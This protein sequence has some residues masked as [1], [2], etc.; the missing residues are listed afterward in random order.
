[1]FFVLPLWAQPTD[2]PRL[3]DITTLDQLYAIR[4]DM[5]GDGIPDTHT[6]DVEKEAYREAFSLAADVNNVCV[7]EDGNAASCRGYELMKDLDFNDED[8]LMDGAQPSKWAKNCI[9]DCITGTKADGRSGNTGWEPIYY[10]NDQGTSIETDDV[11]A[12]FSMRLHGNGLTISNLYINRQASADAIYGGLFGRT[13]DAT[14]DSLGLEQIEIEVENS[15]GRAYAG[16]LVGESS[17]PTI[18]ACYATG[19]LRC[20]TTNISGFGQSAYAGGLV[21]QTTTNGRNGVISCYAKVNVASASPNLAYVGG[22]V[23]GGSGIVSSY[24]TGSVTCVGSGSPDVGGL[25]GSGSGITSSYATGNVTC[26]GTGAR[27]SAGGLVGFGSGKVSASYATGNVTSAITSIGTNGVTNAGGL[28]GF[29]RSMISACYATGDVRSASAGSGTSAGG[30]VGRIF[31]RGDNSS[32]IVASYA[33]GDVVGTSASSVVYVGGLVGHAFVGRFCSVIACYATGNVTSAITSI[34]TNGVTNAGGLVGRIDNNSR[35]SNSITACYA[36]GDVESTTSSSFIGGLIG[37]KK[38]LDGSAF[39]DI[40][41]S[42]YSSEATITGGTLNTEGAQT[43]N[44]LQARTTATGIYADW[45]QLELDHEASAGIDDR[46]QVGDAQ[47]DLVWDF[48]TASEYP[49]LMVDF[50]GDPDAVNKATIEEFGPQR[51][52]QFRRDTYDFV[53]GVG[54]TAGTVVNSVEAE[55][56]HATTLSYSIV[57]ETISDPG[58]TSTAFSFAID[59]AGV[60][61]V[62][63]GAVL[64]LDQVYTLMV[65]VNRGGVTD[66]AEVR[67]KVVEPVA[68]TVPTRL[69]AIPV[70]DAQIDLSWEAPISRGG[71]SI[72]GYQLQVSEDEGTTWMDLYMTAAAMLTYEH[73]GLTRGAT[74]YYRIAAIN[75]VGRG[76]YSSAV[77]TATTYDVP[78]EAPNLM[79]TAVSG[80]QIDL[81]WQAP[82]STGGTS[83]TGYQLQVSEDEGITWVDLY[84]TAAT[85][86][87]YEHRGLTRGATRYYRV[88]AVN[89]VGVG[90]YSSAV[91]SATTY[92][93]PTAPTNL[94]ATA[95][96]DAQI[97]L[98]WTVLSD[99]GSVIRG[100]TLEWSTT[101]ATSFGERIT[102]IAA[103]ASSYAH[104]GLEAGTEYSY[105][106]IAINAI[107]DS[108]PS[109][110]SSATTQGVPTAPTNLTATAVGE[111]QID[112]SWSPPSDD[113][114]TPIT[115]YQIGYS[116]NGGTTYND[117]EVVSGVTYQHRDLA[118]RTTYHYRVAAQNRWGVG[119]YAT[120]VAFVGL[121]SVFGL[122]AY[123]SEVIVYPNPTSGVVRVMGLPEAQSYRYRVYTL[124]GQE[125]LSGGLRAGKISLSGLAN[126]QY[127]FVLED[128]EDS[129]LLRT[130]LLVLR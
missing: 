71:A 77:S 99:G 86:L 48:G 125:V 50:D 104:T 49:A 114:G 108:E 89:S 47:D 81:F 40:T 18:V 100:Y 109:N 27:L 61:R 37:Y 51:A 12:R 85:T 34:G 39:F 19:S 90:V 112:L 66:K 79:A 80:N 58:V 82:A 94:R 33:T 5:N 45:V 16:G 2:N 76:I 73:R 21:G 30:L 11:E 28:V 56:A 60:L 54:A 36:T 1:M 57:S 115:G 35:Y 63:T 24:A 103:S 127:V 126:R 116:T 3:I 102:G 32:S 74:R 6:K 38:D 26:T 96:S 88:A 129:E 78:A 41:A 120:L 121:G 111:K 10:F 93:V 52:P 29:S 9:S 31:S 14:L 69:V 64:R 20:R 91:P 70:S 43:R 8:P 95:V 101:G 42:Y 84:M 122:E 23:G 72:T 118:P 130:R 4:Y 83:I 128:E 124:I 53:V 105:R 55:V 97:D 62:A 46:T 110:E 65:Q 25:L 106:L 75:S 13:I 59:N 7:D 22:L 87:T 117:L 98:S 44:A 17:G 68:P 113:G 123:V 67:I 92:D 119:S 15:V 107:G